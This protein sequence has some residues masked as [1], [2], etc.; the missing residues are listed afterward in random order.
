MRQE[1]NV[2]LKICIFCQF[3]PFFF[4][5]IDTFID[6]QSFLFIEGARNEGIQW[7]TRQFLMNSSQT[8]SSTL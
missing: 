5:F 4:L 6:I 1:S 2:R 3:S 8:L 7:L